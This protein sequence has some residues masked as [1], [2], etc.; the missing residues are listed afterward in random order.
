MSNSCLPDLLFSARGTYETQ[1]TAFDCAL[2][3][4]L[5]TK[6]TIGAEKPNQK[7]RALARLSNKNNPYL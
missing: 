5:R 1:P 3:L 2:L 7:P 4:T 6:P